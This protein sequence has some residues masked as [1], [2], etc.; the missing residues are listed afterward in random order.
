MPSDRKRTLTL[1][2]ETLRS[3]TVTEM[4]AIA[5]GAKAPPPTETSHS[6]GCSNGCPTAT[7]KSRCDCCPSHHCL[8][9][10][11]IFRRAV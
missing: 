7:C 1:N 11:M 6:C 9:P 3:L 8:A 10:G 5:G 4:A 2:R